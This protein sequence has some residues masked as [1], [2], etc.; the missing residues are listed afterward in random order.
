M[1]LANTSTAPMSV[2]I[3]G[4]S[5]AFGGLASEL[6]RQLIAAGHK[7]MVMT[8]GSDDARA[9]RAAGAL[10]IY[11]DLYRAGE[12]WSVMQAAKT[13]AVVN[14]TPQSMNHIPYLPVRWDERPLSEGTAALLDAAQQAGVEYF[15]HTSYAYVGGGRVEELAPLLR[16]AARAEREVLSGTIPAAVLRMGFLY[17]ASSLEMN[18]ALNTIKLG[19][20]IEAGTDIPVH[21]THIADAA[22]AILLALEKRPAGVT[23]NVVDDMPASTAEFMRYFTDSQGLGMPGRLP[24]LSALSR[25]KRRLA[26]MSLP[27]HGSNAGSRETLGWQPRFPNYRAGIDD[28]LLTWRAQEPERT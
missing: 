13:N 28:L 21:W 19:R 17:G 26:L 1:A 7:V 27:A 4:A 23:L 8:R 10:P 15:I 12:M 5:E 6:T 20:P 14:L 9:V 11:P 2:Y 18:S 22:S 25:D 3:A 16:A 24:F